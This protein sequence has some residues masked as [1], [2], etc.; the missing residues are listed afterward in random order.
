[1][2]N[3]SWFRIYEC[4]DA[5]NAGGCSFHRWAAVSAWL[6]GGLRQL[7]GAARPHIKAGVGWGGR[8]TRAC[9]CV[10]VCCLIES[11]YSRCYSVTPAPILSSSC[12]WVYTGWSPGSSIGRLRVLTAGDG[13]PRVPSL[14]FLFAAPVP[15]VPFVP[16]VSSV[17]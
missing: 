13:S 3:K 11:S 6:C 1:M 8:W 14:A 15:S 7:V 5:C 12:S 2:Y 17:S 16:T 10:C 9:V 4:C